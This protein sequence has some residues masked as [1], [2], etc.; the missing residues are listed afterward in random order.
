M[1]GSVVNSLTKRGRTGDFRKVIVSQTLGIVGVGEG[2]VE[3]AVRGGGEADRVS[4]V[5]SGEA[6]VSSGLLQGWGH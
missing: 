1:Q 4:G 3:D 6:W 5:E 2:V